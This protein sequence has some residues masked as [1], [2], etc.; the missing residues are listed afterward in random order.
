MARRFAST[1]SRPAP[2]S[3]EPSWSTPPPPTAFYKAR[4][5][6]NTPRNGWDITFTDGTLYQFA[7][8][9]DPG[10]WLIAIRDR[11]GNQ[12]TITRNYPGTTAPVTRVTSPN[13][14][15]VDFT[16]ITVNTVL[17]ISQIRD[18]LGRTVS[19]TYYPNT[20][21]LK[22][23]TDAAGG[24]TEYTWTSARIATIKDPRNIVYLTN[25]YNAQ[26]RVTKQTQADGTFYQFAYTLDGQGKVTQTDVTDPRGNVRR[27][28]FNANGHAL[29]DT[30]AYGTAIAR[31]TTFTRD[32]T[33][34]LVNTMTDAL[35]R[36]TAFTYNSQG[37]AL[38]V[39][40]LAGTGNAVTTTFTY[41]P[42][43][44]QVASITDPLSHPTSFGYD[45]IGNLTTITD[46][47][48]HQTTLTYNAQGQPA[49]I[50]D[51]LTNTTTLD[52]Y[53]GD[54]ATITDPT[55]KTTRRF[56]DGGGRLIAT[57]NPLGQLG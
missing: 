16:Y 9:G 5:T 25:E 21:L 24:V 56:T 55:G 36:Q 27:V 38:T 18:N 23:V 53:D 49:T 15:W 17:L 33:S 1:G 39:T 28:T 12:L 4:L 47:L 35:G 46:A 6:W 40:R 7:A 30:Q 32:A 20:F 45:S 42:T 22:T 31:T 51:A 37:Q 19:Y 29:T 2:T 44:N 50:Q 8:V 10:P 52:Y 3:R 43:F 34:N 26:G 48:T 14:R 11:A 13:G 54:L 41:E 57:T